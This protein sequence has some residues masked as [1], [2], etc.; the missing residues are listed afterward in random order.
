MQIDIIE[1]D[2][3]WTALT[4]PG[5]AEAAAIATFARLGIDAD[6]CTLSLLAC[7]DARIAELNA[8]FRGKPQ[9]TNVLSWPA[10]DLA[11]AD[12]GAVP[13]APEPDFAGETE[14]GDIAI[15][16]ETC[17]REAET[18]GK[19]M[20]DHVTHLLVHGLLHLLGYDHVR[21]PDATLMERLEVEILGRLGLD[22]PYRDRTGP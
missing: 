19:P 4:L 18:A 22:D 14:L 8:E 20:A 1:D 11:A 13:A 9:P 2:P 12:P 3:R 7:D 6:G 21:D 15:A 10:A 17:A 5:L 16:W